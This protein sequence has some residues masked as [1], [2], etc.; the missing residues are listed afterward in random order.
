MEIIR[1]LSGYSSD[2]GTVLAIGNFDGLHLGHQAILKVLK[3][4]SKQLGLPAVILTFYPMVREFFAKDN[5][6]PRL[7]SF[8]EKNTGLKEFGIDIVIWQLFN[9]RLASIKAEEFVKDILIDKLKIKALVLG[10]NFRFGYKRAGDINLLES[11]AA[12]FGFELVQID[13][14]VSASSSQGEVSSSAVRQALVEN[15]LN[16]AKSL[17]GRMYS[18][19]G[20]VVHGRKLATKMGFPTVNIRL[21]LRDTL[22]IGGVYV[23]EVCFLSY[24]YFGVANVGSKPTISGKKLSLEVHLFMDDRDLYGVELK[25]NFLHFLRA[26]KKFSSLQDL[27][28]QVNQDIVLA[29]QWLAKTLKKNKYKDRV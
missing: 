22:P 13:K 9:Q 21:G 17:L 27:K 4:K 24:K 2:S 28:E 15:K 25:T 11:F 7:T 23:V 6:V 19:S 16:F 1:G 18:I 26:E 3:E 14:F 8:K 29:K 20:R 12:D 5:Q 10:H